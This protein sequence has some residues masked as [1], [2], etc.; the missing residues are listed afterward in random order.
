MI[1]VGKRDLKRMWKQGFLVL[2]MAAFV[3]CSTFPLHEEQKKAPQKPAEPAKKTVETPDGVK[4]TPYE[5]EEIKRKPVRVVVPEQKAKQQFNDGRSLPAFKNLIQQTQMA[6]R[7]QKWDDAERFAL[8]AQ[9]LAP[10][11]AETF[12]YLALVANQKGQYSSA[13]SLAR[14]G[15]SYAQSAPM[16]K[17]LWQAILVAGQKQNHAQTVQQAQQALNSL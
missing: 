6:Y 14:R 5:Q 9:R 7:Q 12:M 4:I 11:A 2:I 10:Q 17:Q 1:T 15:L 13:E 3:G 16:K 8:Q